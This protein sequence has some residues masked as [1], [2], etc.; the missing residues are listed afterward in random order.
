[1]AK[2]CAFHVKIQ[3]SET[4]VFWAIVELTNVTRKRAETS[5][6]KICGPVRSAIQN[7]GTDEEIVIIL[8]TMP[9]SF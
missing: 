6:K 1:M 2:F 4:A 9:A 3:G 5:L 8:V 7:N